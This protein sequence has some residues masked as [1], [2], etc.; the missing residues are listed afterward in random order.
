MGEFFIQEKRA[1]AKLARISKRS[2]PCMG[3]AFLL[4][5]RYFFISA[6]VKV[7]SYVDPK[8][9]SWTACR[10]VLSA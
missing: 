8:I 5:D 1:S 4:E 10:M 2:R 3:S 9:R 6:K 7:I